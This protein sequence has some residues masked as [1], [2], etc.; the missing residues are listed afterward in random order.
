MRGKGL[1]EFKDSNRSEMCFGGH[2]MLNLLFL[3]FCKYVTEC[4]YCVHNNK[5]LCFVREAKFL[6]YLSYC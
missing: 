2:K 3:A 1:G 6:E 5:A 4:Y